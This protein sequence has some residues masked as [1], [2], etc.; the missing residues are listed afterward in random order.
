MVIF[1]SFNANT[2][3]NDRRWLASF[4]KLKG[5]DSLVKRIRQ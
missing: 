2:L 5:N 3:V 4:D 1:A